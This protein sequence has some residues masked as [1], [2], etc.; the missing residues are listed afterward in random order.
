MK[1][2]QKPS[3]VKVWQYYAEPRTKVGTTAD[4]IILSVAP[5]GYKISIPSEGWS[6]TTNNKANAEQIIAD[7]NSLP[8]RYKQKASNPRWD[9]I[10]RL[11][12]ERYE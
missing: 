12:E 10:R 8:V 5:E 9:Y 1:N 11:E 3:Q 6:Y 4:D 2:Y 7:L